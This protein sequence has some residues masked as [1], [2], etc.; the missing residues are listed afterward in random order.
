MVTITLDERDSAILTALSRGD[1]TIE[2]LADGV[3]CPPDYLRDRLPELADNGLVRR[4]DD[5]VYTVT[6][7]GKRVLAGSPAG[8]MD[9]RIDTPAPVEREIRSFELRPDR[10]EAVRNAYA[11]LHYWGEAVESEII[12]GVY[13][14]N[15]AGFDS[16]EKWWTEFVRERLA[17]LPLVESPDSAGEPWRYSGTPTVEE[18]TEDGRLAPDDGATA[19]TSVKFALEQSELS[20]EERSAVRAVFESL[21]R[22]GEASAAEIRDR[23]YPDHD[24][25]YDSAAEWWADCVRD[26]LRM[27]PGVE[28][29]DDGRDVWQYHG[30]DEGVTS[31]GSRGEASGE[32]VDRQDDTDE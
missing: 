16:D 19:R 8:T 10:E 31:S 2:S 20:E 4:V 30:A 1:A 23:V 26:G 21:V 15:P 24:A 13:S 18:V 25:G 22:S 5:D 3:T 27:L 6:A 29:A 7:N 28:R 14:E 32:S 17:D 11:F 9:D 12:D